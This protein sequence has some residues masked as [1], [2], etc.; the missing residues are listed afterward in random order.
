MLE[1]TVFR[2]SIIRKK[3]DL[4]DYVNGDDD[5]N[6]DDDDN[7]DDSPGLKLF[8]ILS[9]RRSLNQFLAV[10]TLTCKPRITLLTKRQHSCQTMNSSPLPLRC[11]H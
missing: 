9:Q 1:F 3:I 2:F 5:I 7:G 8:Q 6:G 10:A 4:D 11:L